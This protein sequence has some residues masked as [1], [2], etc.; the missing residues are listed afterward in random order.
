MK[1]VLL[2]TLAIMANS[3]FVNAQ[4]LASVRDNDNFGYINISGTMVITPQF[5][6]AGDFSEGYAAA[7]KDK[8]W[9]FIDTSGKWVI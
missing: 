8:K 5:E 9:G 6:K 1:K 3:T 7:F 2:L 4:E